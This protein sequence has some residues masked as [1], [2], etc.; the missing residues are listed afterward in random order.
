MFGTEVSLEMVAGGDRNTKF[1][2]DTTLQRRER[3]RIQ[4]IKDDQGS[5]IEGKEEVFKAVL[6]HF[7]KIYKAGQIQDLEECMQHVPKI[8]I[9]EMNAKLMAQVED[10][11][12]KEA[13]FSIGALKAP[14]PDGFNALFYQKNWETIKDDIGRAVKD[15]FLN[16]NISEEVNETL[17]ALAPKVPLPE[18]INQLRPISCCNVVAKI[19]SK[20]FVEIKT[21]YGCDNL[22]ES[23]CF[24]RWK[25]DSR[26]PHHCT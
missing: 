7:Q 16:G 10:K 11:Q 3:N 21:V 18:C 22:S 4:R 15:F 14:S 8:V 26:Q 6:E 1:F 12:I 9:E 23:E 5:W 24:C 25:I 13:V 19:I 20:I 17:V 2:H